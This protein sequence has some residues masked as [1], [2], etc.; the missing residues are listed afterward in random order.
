MD[1]NEKDDNFFSKKT[2]LHLGDF[3]K[4]FIKSYIKIDFLKFKQAKEEI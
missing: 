1:I 2:P 4:I 3:L